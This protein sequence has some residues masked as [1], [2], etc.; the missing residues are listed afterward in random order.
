MV[1]GCCQGADDV[2]EELMMEGGQGAGESCTEPSNKTGNTLT[3]RCSPSCDSNQNDG[4]L[5]EPDTAV[6]WIEGSVAACLIVG[7]PS[8]SGKSR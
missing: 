1:R 6:V 7:R 2:L 5:R 3:E 4:Q 8:E